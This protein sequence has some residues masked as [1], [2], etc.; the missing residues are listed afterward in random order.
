[1]TEFRSQKTAP[2]EPGWYWARATDTPGDPCPVLV[3]SDYG[4]L[5][6]LSAG[7]SNSYPI[8]D[9]DW[10]GSLLMVKEG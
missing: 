10:F 3:I 5:K 1:M 2:S 4:R 8:P 6:V 7:S 9:Y